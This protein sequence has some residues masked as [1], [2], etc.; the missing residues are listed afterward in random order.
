MS[1]WLL[2]MD[3]LPL[4][5]CLVPVAGATHTDRLLLTASHLH[6]LS[7]LPN[8]PS[9]V[10]AGTAIGDPPNVIIVSDSRITGAGIGFLDF[11]LHL[12][13][14]TFF[15]FIGAFFFVRWR[16]KQSMIIQKPVSRTLDRGVRVLCAEL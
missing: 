5:G 14:G 4:F 9:F 3:P 2:A 12:L 16:D 6:A 1:M 13:P 7:C 15:C 10:H 11:T 8:T